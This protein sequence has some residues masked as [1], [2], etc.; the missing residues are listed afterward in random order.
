MR[1]FRLLLT[2]ITWLCIAPSLSA[3]SLKEELKPLLAGP[4]FDCHGPGTQ[5]AG[6]RLDTLSAD[7]DDVALG[8]SKCSANFLRGK[9]RRSPKGVRL[10]RY[11]ARASRY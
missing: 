8:G 7:L 6:L 9:C 11:C 10:R 3:E 5:E 4:C 2:L 1:S